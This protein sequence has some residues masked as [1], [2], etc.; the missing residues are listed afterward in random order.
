MYFFTITK[1]TGPIFRKIW[2]ASFFS[3]MLCVGA[4]LFFLAVGAV[5]ATFSQRISPN[6]LIVNEPA[7]LILTSSAAVPRIVH[8]P[9]V[10]GISWDQNPP[11]IQQRI[12]IIGRKRTAAYTARYT[13]QADR[14]GIFI[15]PSMKVRVGR[16]VLSTSALRFK[17]V[18]AAV[19]SSTGSRVL[20]ELYWDGNPT[21]PKSVYQGQVLTG[22]FRVLVDSRLHLHARTFEQNY[23]PKIDLENVVFRDYSGQDGSNGTFLFRRP[24]T[25]VRNGRRYQV[26]DYPFAISGISVGTISGEITHHIPLLRQRRRQI[27][28]NLFS[29][30]FSTGRYQL[31]QHPVK[32]KI[33]AIKVLPLPPAPTDKGVFLGIVGQWKLGLS[34]DHSQVK[35]GEGVTLLLTIDGKGGIENLS[36]PRLELSG[37]RLYPP[38]IEKKYFPH[39]HGKISWLAVPGKAGAKLPSFIFCTFDAKSGKYQRY[40][41]H[42]SLTVLPSD[43]AQPGGVVVGA[44]PASHSVTKAV[45]HSQHEI[46]YL[47]SVAESSLKFPLWRNAMGVILGGGVLAPLF[48]S[49]LVLWLRWRAALSGDE[50]ARRLRQARKQR[51]ALVKALKVAAPEDLPEVIRTRLVP[52][53]LDLLDLPRGTTLAEVARQLDDR[54][55]GDI[56]KQAETSAFMPGGEKSIDASFL[57]RKLKRFGPWLLMAGLVM[58]AGSMRAAPVAAVAEDSP[59]AAAAAYDQGRVAQAE[60]IYRRLL[61]KRALDPAL[62][63]NLGNCRYRQGDYAG[64]IACYECALRLAPGDSDILDNLNFVYRRLDLPSVREA[65]SPVA[66][67]RNLRDRLRP[68]QWL[69][70]ATFGWVMFWLSAAVLRLRRR[71]W[72]P[73]VFAWWILI[74]L[75]FFA[76]TTQYGDTYLPGQAVVVENRAPVYRWPHESSADPPQMRLKAG[77]KVEVREHRTGWSRIRIDQ[78]EGWIENS[79]LRIYWTGTAS[80]PWLRS[81]GAHAK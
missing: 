20:T 17:V 39:E 32:M 2:C 65:G 26:F 27:Q 30:F 49:L 43:S 74:L 29:Q 46:H 62:L 57:I 77:D 42:P 10:D 28:N 44:T 55:L 41:F 76:L 19:S 51:G 71:P 53:L 81:G 21:P 15:I 5:G 8:L 4:F 11:S 25:M 48:F 61:A 24:G 45:R 70:V 22:L 7:A 3:R 40:A 52:Y 9:Q 23:F 59:A 36:P 16:Q 54:E 33:P 75:A 14:A 67:L 80:L 72:S 73:L 38:Q 64:A 13:F 6:P 37:F 66:A 56:L 68:D 18:P 12:Q 50:R 31:I 63:Y 79:Y 34:V 1:R 69:L 35:V 47:H 78:A 60:K 58:G